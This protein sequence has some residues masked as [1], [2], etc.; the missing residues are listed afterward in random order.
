MNNFLNYRRIMR[1]NFRQIEY[2]DFINQI[3]VLVFI[4]EDRLD[5]AIK[6]IEQLKPDD[7]ELFETYAEPGLVK[8]IV[9][10]EKILLNN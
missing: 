1:Q 2:F 5:G 3:G 4:S 7:R 6:K 10:N 8:E 9:E